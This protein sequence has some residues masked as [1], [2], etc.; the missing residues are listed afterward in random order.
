[1]DDLE[2]RSTCYVPAPWALTGQGWVVPQ[3]QHVDEIAAYVPEGLQIVGWHGWTPG[4]YVCVDYETSPVGP[5]REILFVPALVRL[6]RK[7]GFHVSHIYVD[8]A[9]SVV[10]G[11]KNWWLPKDLLRF[12]VERQEHTIIFRADRNDAAVATG[13]WTDTAAL[14][15]PFNNRWLPLTLLQ[16]QAGRFRRSHFWARGRIGTA[17]GALDVCDGVSLPRPTRII[18]LPLLSIS[19]FELVFEQGTTIPTQQS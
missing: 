1:M 7:I 4:G 19:H 8:N 5:Y 17:N 3:L 12:T 10:G 2:V 18:R 6:D 13:V 15:I 11:Q 14:R 9:A 16:A